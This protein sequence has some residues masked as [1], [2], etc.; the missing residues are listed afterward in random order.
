LDDFLHLWSF[1]FLFFKRSIHNQT[2]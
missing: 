1:L 2:F